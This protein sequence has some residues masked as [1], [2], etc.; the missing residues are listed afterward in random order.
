LT[1]LSRALSKQDLLKF[2]ICRK[3]PRARIVVSDKA[4]DLG[5]SATAQKYFSP[6]FIG[7]EVE[8]LEPKTATHP[9]VKEV[10]ARRLTQAEFSPIAIY[11]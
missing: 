9:F 4:R 3:A 8:G 11:S 7:S 2:Q 5:V 6:E 10:E 1:L